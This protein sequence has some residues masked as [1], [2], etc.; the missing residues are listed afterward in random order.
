MNKPQLPNGL[1]SILSRR[2]RYVPAADTDVAKT[3]ARI[4][5]DLEREISRPAVN[6]SLPKAPKV[7]FD[8]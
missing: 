8:P 4:R 2:F 1:P 7:S 3:F 5:Q 6:V